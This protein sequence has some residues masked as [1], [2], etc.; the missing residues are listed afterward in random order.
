M[1]HVPIRTCVVTK[2]ATEKENLIRITKDKTGFVKVDLT[3][4]AQGRGAYITKS[5]DVILSA[6]KKGHLSRALGVT[7]PPSIYE[8]LKMLCHE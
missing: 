4:K 5:I 6:E 7:I 8:E 2:L 1:K 3:G